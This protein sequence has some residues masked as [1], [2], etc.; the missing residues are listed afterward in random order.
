MR[1]LVASDRIGS[2]S[3]L[4]AGRLI[5]A[6]WPEAA[7]R[8]MPV[9][10]AG[11]GFIEAYAAAIGVEAER[12]AGPDGV[13][14]T[15]RSTAGWAVGWEPAAAPAAELPYGVSSAP[16]G[17]A[18][19]SA[20]AGGASRVFVDL[21]GP[22][23]HDAGAGLLAA[24]GARAD[25]PLDGGVEPL[26]R[27][28]TL[29]L[30][31]VRTAVGKT[32]L[33]GVVP[34]GEPAALLLGLRGITSRRGREYG[35]DPAR[36]LA[37]DAAL[38]RFAGVV[39]P[40]LAAAAGSGA[41]GG[42]GLALLAL[43]GRLATGPS[44]TLTTTD[45]EPR[46]DLVLTGCS[47]FDFAHRG[48]EVVGAAARLATSLLV[49]CVLLA[50]EVFVGSREQRA[51]GIEAS[52]AVRG[53]SRTGRAGVAPHDPGWSPSEAALADLSRRVARTWTW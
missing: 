39:A 11:A 28:S 38:E 7:T 30:D 48:G 1:I 33:I 42:L 6:G 2:A 35:E 9:G 23:V 25:V 27:L 47:V 52:Y 12:A 13:A 45:E 40:G 49:P 5:A 10:A 36:M 16:L 3:S 20:L 29:D 41:C 18:L 34:E 24:L 26:A 19:R 4:R 44:V 22:D 37:A 43:G 53:D 17:T 14:T 31:A 32:E 50:G 15:V 51:M 46:P 8:V 21:A